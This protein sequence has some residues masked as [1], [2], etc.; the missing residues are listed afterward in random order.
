MEAGTG[1]GASI[2][3]TARSWR[4][5]GLQAAG[6]SDREAYILRA[7]EWLRS[8]QN[9]DGGWGESCA[10]Y[11]NN[12]LR[13]G[14]Q[15]AFANRLGDPGA[16]RRR[17]HHQQQPAQGHRI[18]DRNPA[19]RT[20]AGTRSCPPAPVS[21]AFSICNIT[22]TGIRSR[23]W[24]CRS[25]LK[26][27]SANGAD[28]IMRFPLSQAAGMATYIAKNK[29]RPQAGVAEERGA[30]PTMR[31]IRS[32]SSTR[33]F[34]RRRADR[35]PHPMINKRFPLVMMLEPLHAC[36]LTCTGCGRIREYEDSIRDRADAGTMPE[37]GRRVRRAHGFDLRRRA[38]ALSR[39]RRSCARRF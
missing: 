36:N 16:A 12:T 19:Q 2:T 35:K 29:M 10:S 33:R 17:R 8:I 32:A 30:M 9:A 22:C 11:D 37:G 38:A 13:A 1:A 39:D 23:C 21:R 26:T 6:E 34:R 18:S 31:R 5:A 7:G 24:P 4:C 27:R 15:H 3:S 25:Y 20:A 28:R 14:R